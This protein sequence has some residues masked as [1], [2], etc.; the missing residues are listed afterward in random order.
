MI[1]RA[2]SRLKPRRSSADIHCVHD[3]PDIVRKLVH[4][5]AGGHRDLVA[6]LLELDGDSVVIGSPASE[7]HAYVPE[8]AE[9]VEVGLITAEGIVWYTGVVSEREPTAE[10]CLRVRLGENQVGCE[11]RANPRAPYSL[12]I[13]LTIAGAAEPLAGRLLDVSTGGVRLKAS[14]ALSIGDL[15]G[16]TVHVP[17]G[18]PIQATARVVHVHPDTSGLQFELALASDRERLVRRAFE[19]LAFVGWRQSQPVAD[20]T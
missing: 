14:A 1:S 9:P 20:Q 12:S 8:F 19:R 16:I 13:D 11:Q 3:R 17:G 2:R 10:R 4:V 6:R 7:T 15:V 18:Q 5:R